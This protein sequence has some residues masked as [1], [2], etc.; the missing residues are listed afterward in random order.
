LA[1][2]Q[3]LQRNR[4][5]GVYVNFMQ[6][7]TEGAPATGRGVNVFLNASEPAEGLNAF[8]NA[9]FSV[10]RCCSTSRSID[11]RSWRYRVR[12]MS[13]RRTLLRRLNRADYPGRGWRASQHPGC[14][15]A[16]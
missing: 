15:F 14:V 8:F 2:G 1:G 9:T 13:R 10:G 12:P 11:R 3:P 5:Y 4:A 16:V 7:L 6:Q